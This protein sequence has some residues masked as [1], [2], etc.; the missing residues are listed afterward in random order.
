KQ[1]I[2][3]RLT[4]ELSIHAAIEEQ[5]LYPALRRASSDGMVD[6]ALS[7]HQEVKEVL[8]KL[9][10][11]RPESQGYDDRVRQLMQDVMHHAKEE[12]REM[13]PKLR[14]ALK[15]KELDQLGEQMRMAKKAAPTRP[16]PKAPNKPPAN[17]AA[18][19]V[20]AVVD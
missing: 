2:V 14:K 6:E 18:G 19:A 12:E 8:A 5:L 9:E 3:G 13:L 1:H 15:K 17:M 7:E 20:A 10:K 11:M 4:K 16:H